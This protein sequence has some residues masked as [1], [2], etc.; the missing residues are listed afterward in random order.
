MITSGAKSVKICLILDPGCVCQTIVI[1]LKNGA[2]AQQSLK[3]GIYQIK[4]RKS[5]WKNKLDFI[6]YV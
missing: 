5:E 1:T 4:S 3:Q 2:L 6:K